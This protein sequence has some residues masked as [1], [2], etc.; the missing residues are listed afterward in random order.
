MKEGP[1]RSR[2]QGEARWTNIHVSISHWSNNSNLG[3]LI[4]RKDLVGILQQNNRFRIKLTCNILIGL[5]V[6]RLIDLISRHGKIALV[7]KAHG[8]FGG[9]NAGYCGVHH[10]HLECAIGDHG[11]NGT[12]VE[13]SA[14]HLDVCACCECL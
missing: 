6:Y 4:K 13:A 2:G 9:E 5:S 8:E 1:F 7:E 11:G 3:I 12:V 10:A 14:A